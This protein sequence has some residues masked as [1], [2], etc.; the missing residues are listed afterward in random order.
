MTKAILKEIR[1][2]KA[3]I[4]DD[5]VDDFTPKCF[6]AASYGKDKLAVC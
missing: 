5:I 1:L 2:K 3:D 4:I 6:V